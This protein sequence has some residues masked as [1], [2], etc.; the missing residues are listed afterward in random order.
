MSI[1]PSKAATEHQ[2]RTFHSEDYI[3]YIKAM[4]AKSQSVI[5]DP[6]NNELDHSIVGEE[7]GFGYDCAAIKNTMSLISNLAGGTLAAA[8]AVLSGQFKVAINWT[9]GWHHGL[10]DEASGYCY[11]ND[12]VIAILEVL[13]R[14]VER[15]LYIDYDLHHGDGVESAFAH[16]KKVLTGELDNRQCSW[17]LIQFIVCDLVS[18][19]KY[20]VGF[21][22]GTGSVDET[23]FGRNGKGYAVNVPIKDGIGDDLY[24]WLANEVLIAAVENY[25]PQ[26]V[27]AQF[28]ADT[29]IEDP[30][31]GFNLTLDGPANCLK[32]LMKLDLPTVILGGGGYNLVNTAKLWTHLTGLVVGKELDLQIPDHR[33]FLDYRPSYE[34]FIEK[35]LR[36][37]SNSKQELEIIL[38]GVKNNL[39]K[40]KIGNQF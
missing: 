6:E 38:E 35:G 7:Y 12:I 29:L 9:G 31:K 26:L 27:F 20:E 23:G 21:F 8:N 24:S 4:D 28:G 22:P 2:L 17:L 3:N 39:S 19:H 11:V 10:K 37:D 5:H 13:S 25:K 34:L 15:V 30:M 40:I 14:G 33:F 18:L 16:S 36:K 32:Q 1:I